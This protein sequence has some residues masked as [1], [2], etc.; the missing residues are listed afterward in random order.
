[1]VRMSVESVRR[2]PARLL[3]LAHAGLDLTS[4]L[5]DPVPPGLGFVIGLTPGIAVVPRENPAT[6]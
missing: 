4:D 5:T 1:M 2:A 3:D 6:P